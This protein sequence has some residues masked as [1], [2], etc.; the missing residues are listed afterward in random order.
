MKTPDSIILT[1]KVV[2]D[3]LDTNEEKLQMAGILF[4]KNLITKLD[5]KVLVSY[6]INKPVVAQQPKVILCQ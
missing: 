2:L 5:H 3:S 4:N 1:A 6:I